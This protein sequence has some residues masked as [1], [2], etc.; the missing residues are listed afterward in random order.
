MDP[1]KPIPAL[2]K[3]DSAPREV[4]I[5]YVVREPTY[6]RWWCAG[7]QAWHTKEEH[8]RCRMNLK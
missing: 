1:T 6:E 5:R 4:Y 3:T 8:D 2:A 7:C